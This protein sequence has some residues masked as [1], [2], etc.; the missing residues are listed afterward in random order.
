MAK[1]AAAP[2]FSIN[3][4]TD[5]QNTSHL[6]SLLK[7]N[8]KPIFEIGSELAMFGGKP[9]SAAIGA[10]P[11]KITIRAPGQWKTSTKTP[12]GFDLSVTANCHIS[13]SDKSSKLDIAKSIESDETD[14]GCLGPTSGVTY[15]NID[16]D[17][18]VQGDATASGGSGA[19]SISGKA[20]GSE[21]TTYSFSYPAN[22][23]TETLAAVKEAFA[24]LVIPFEPNC[25]LIM[26]NTSVCRLNFDASLGFE[27]DATYGFASYQFSAPGVDMVKA[28]IDK[29]TL[30]NGK[31]DAGLKASFG[32]TH[33]DHFGMIVK[34]LDNNSA[35]LDV[36]RSAENETTASG[37][38]TVGISSTGTLNATL[39]KTALASAVDRVTGV[40]GSGSKVADVA[41]KVQSSLVSKTNNWLS[42]QKGDAGLMVSLSRQRKRA[43]LY[44]FSVDLTKADL[45]KQS[46]SQLSNADLGQAMKIGGMKLLPG[47]GV[48]DQLK[49]SVGVSL[50]FFNLF[51]VTDKTTY[52]QNSFVDIGP[53]G[54]PRFL[55]DVGEE[56][57]VDTK[58]AMKK[59]R[60]HFVATATPEANS[61]TK[62]DVDLC[63]EI[64]ETNNPIEGPKIAA[65][66]GGL[67][68]VVKDAQNAMTQF[69]ASNKK[70]TLNLVTTFK[71]SA[72]ERLA[73]SQFIGRKPPAN[74]QQQDMSNFDA[75]LAAC[76]AI[77]QFVWLGTLSYADWVQFN[78][79]SIGAV[80][81][82]GV[83]LAN[84]TPNR[85]SFGPVSAVPD[86]FFNNRHASEEQIKAFYPNCARFMN[87]CDDLHTLAGMVRELDEQ[88]TMTEW[89]EVLEFITHLVKGDAALADFGKPAASAL[90][91]L[92]AGPAVPG[93]VVTRL[94]PSTDKK[95]LTCTVTLS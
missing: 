27:L 11:A 26:P 67:G 66:V 2:N 12:I 29:L 54:N 51:A 17:F 35:E 50:H 78:K 23:N 95:S 47:S 87:L 92:C 32:Y 71:K 53:D 79:F 59:C 60:L 34:R 88:E 73:C 65:S 82:D 22:S 89:N 90:M 7:G 4:V 36:L 38:I 5:L 8:L 43:S 16:M 63:I 69:V 75:F 83:P 52:F 33:S 80:D 44:K 19:F 6:V 91:V 18:E 84:A 70:S 39:D 10:Q 64:S 42:A 85:R 76:K 68:P 48:G 57:E 15:V 30:P 77:E 94:D 40:H 45:T 9:I 49:R 86:S 72:Y 13:V 31:L 20:T 58:N 3:V 41:D 37:G 93:A 28:S 55:F 61:V 25:A 1:P 46:W 14:D 24:Q 81:S 21:V 74:P 56:S 62:A